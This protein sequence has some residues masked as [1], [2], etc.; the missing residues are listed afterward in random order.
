M[1][2]L[3]VCSLRKLLE[4]LKN[5]VTDVTDVVFVLCHVTYIVPN[6]IR[7]F[8]HVSVLDVRHFPPAIPN[9]LGLILPRGFFPTM[10]RGWRG[11]TMHDRKKMLFIWVSIYLEE[12]TNWGHQFLLLLL[13]T[14]P[15]FYVVVR[16]TRRSG[17]LQSKDSTFIPQLFEDPEDWFGSG[18]R[19]QDLPLCSIVLYRL[20]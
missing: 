13:E 19:T 6:T 18:N 9:S 10:L 8:C 4:N 2:Y 16:A 5:L 1:Q 15:P 14:G 12:R 17:R 3:S 20:S 7:V 11:M